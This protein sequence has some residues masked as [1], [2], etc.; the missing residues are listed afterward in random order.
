MPKIP[1]TS[2]FSSSQQSHK[3]SPE[4]TEPLNKQCAKRATPNV[5]ESDKMR[6]GTQKHVYYMYIYIYIK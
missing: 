4:N 2:P 3:T 6:K 5:F 1:S